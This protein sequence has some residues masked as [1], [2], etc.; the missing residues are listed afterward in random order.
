M[1]PRRPN[2]YLQDIAIIN[3]SKSFGPSSLIAAFEHPE[4][5]DGGSVSKKVHYAHERKVVTG[6][7]Y[8]NPTGLAG[9]NDNFATLSVLQNA[10]VVATQLTDAN[11]GGIT[12]DANAYVE[13]PLAA[14]VADRVV[15]VGEELACVVAEAGTTTVPP[16]RFEIW[17]KSIPDDALFTL[18][19]ARKQM[20]VDRV[21]LKLVD[22]IAASDTNY[23]TFLFGA[24]TPKV[25]ADLTFT[26][27]NDD[28]LLTAA[29]HGLLTGDGPVRVANSGGALPTG[30]VAATDYWVI[31]STADKFYL[32]T[33]LNNALAGNFIVL[34]SDGTGTQTLS[35]TASTKRATNIADWD[36]RAANEGALSAD[37]FGEMDL[38]VDTD[39]VVAAGD[40]FF[41]HCSEAGDAVLSDIELVIH[42]RYL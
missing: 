33:S 17:G 28:D 5:A 4:N 13:L 23:Y 25:I 9:H 42:G 12:L 30:L 14:A 29:A 41:L 40:V 27:E 3:W 36:T 35:D 2:D 22:G 32:A 24:L 38:L 18:A 1:A 10:V 39:T 20:K 31:K 6:V 37:V 15:E 7:R 16:G 19:R 8:V 11:G 21:D 34:G 26:G